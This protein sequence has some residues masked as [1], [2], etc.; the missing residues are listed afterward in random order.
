M[1]EQYIKAIAIIFLSLC[2]NKVFFLTFQPADYFISQSLKIIF[3][4]FIIYLILSKIFYTKD[5]A[6]IL[7]F[8]IFGFSIVYIKDSFDYQ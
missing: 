5:K 7:C 6:F 3:L 2:I 8:S 4:L 1:R